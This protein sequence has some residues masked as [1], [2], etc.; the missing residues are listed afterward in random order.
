[1]RRLTAPSATPREADLA[2]RVVTELQE[3]ILGLVDGAR[4]GAAHG[5]AQERC[6]NCRGAP[7]LCC[8]TQCRSS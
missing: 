3:D 6:A 8:A 5:L 4:Q 7:S 2:A 1:M